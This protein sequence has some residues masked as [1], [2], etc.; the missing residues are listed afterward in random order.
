MSGGL[1]AVFAPRRVAVVGASDE[2]GKVGTTFMRNLESFAGEVVPINP[3]REHVGDRRAYATLADVPG[4]IDLAVAIVPAAAVPGVV[5][6]AVRAQVGAVVVIS[7]G[8]AEVGAEGAA[9]QERVIEAARRGGVR[10]V[11]PNCLG[12]Q[13]SHLGLNATMSLGSSDG[14]GRITLATQSGAYGMAIYMLGQEQQMRFA[15]LYAAGNKADISDTE[16]LEY[17]GEDNDSAVLCFF[18]ESLT[19]GRRFCEAARRIA[20][21]KPILVTKTGRTAAG[22]RAAV[23]HTA[24]LAGRAEIWRAALEQSGVVIAGSGLEMID[25]ARALDWQPVPRGGRVAIISNSGGTGVELTDLLVEE[26]LSVP[27]LSPGLQQALAERL[28]SLGSPRNPV[29]VTTVWARFAALYPFCV[30]RLARSGEV[31][32]VIPVLLQRSAQDRAVAEGLREVVGKLAAD[33][34]EVPVYAC[35][36]AP[37]DARPNLELLQAAGVP[38]Y[39]WPA[40]TARAVALARRYGEIRFGHGAARGGSADDGDRR[41]GAAGAAAAG[42]TADGGTAAVVL[43]PGPMDAGAAAR[44]AGTFGITVPSQEVV[45]QADAAVDAA[46]R[47]GFPVVVKLVSRELTHKSE[48]GGVRVGLADADAVRHAAREI[49]SLAGDA[50]VM[51]QPMLSGVEV[52]VGGFR[53]PQ[54]GPVVA[55]GLG[56]IFVE[57]LADVAFA[58]APLDES[59][60]LAALR[61]LRGFAVLEGAR[62]QPAADLDAVAAVVAGA[63]R[64]LAAVPTIAELDLNPVLAGPDGAVAVDVRVIGGAG[65]TGSPRA[66][67]PPPDAA[68]VTQRNGEADLLARS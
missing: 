35:W 1:D 43:G 66:P 56:G 3:A 28:P 60:A 61:S 12:V 48:V 24:A 20:P 33:G 13:N 4:R 59:E 42:G 47:L 17:L 8:F 6:D 27:E 58:L 39:E 49:L 32:I 65:A 22:M 34:I 36:V 37:A 25:A 67:G 52:I 9:L 50:E 21:R 30:D 23:S 5:A 40:R 57:V 31:D 29:D 14:G 7:G 19:D 38:C 55:V 26:G 44:L 53:D 63:S 64:M 15:K 41:A 68:G 46:Q 18:M 16:V 62:G 54:F 10:V 2:P 11:G 51:V 45:G